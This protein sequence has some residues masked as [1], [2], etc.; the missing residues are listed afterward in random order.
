MSNKILLVDDEPVTA[1]AEAEQLKKH[2]FSV[3]T[4]HSGKKSIRYIDE[5]DDIDLILMDIE[6]NEELD[7]IETAKIIQEDHDIPILFLTAYEN[8]G[9][10]KRVQSTDS[11][12]YL[13]K[14]TSGQM[15]ATAVHQA[16][17]L[18]QAQQKIKDQNERLQKKEEQYRKIVQSSHDA[19]AII[20]NKKIYFSNHAFSHMTGYAKSEVEGRSIAAIDDFKSIS[21]KLDFIKSADEDKKID[22]EF[23]ITPEKKDVRYIKARLIKIDIHNKPA[24]VLTMYDY[25][26]EKKLLEKVEQ[27]SKIADKLG[28]FIP[29]CAG[30]KKIREENNGTNQWTEPESYISNRLPDVQFTHGICPDC[31]EKLYPQYSNKEKSKSYK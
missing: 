5:N 22:L 20:K 26:E 24:F 16:L 2:G 10:L 30:C 4:I 21:K 28:N 19:M 31:R 23:E 15:I 6:L 12:N 7:G 9:F 1:L 13:L 29:I 3:K 14:N 17:K 8:P 11:Y 18:H 27:A 25:T